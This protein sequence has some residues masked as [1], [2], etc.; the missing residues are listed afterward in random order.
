MALTPSSAAHQFCGACV[1]RE[2]HPHSAHPYVYVSPSLQDRKS[3]PL[4]FILAGLGLPSQM[5]GTN[6]QNTSST[7]EFLSLDI[8]KLRASTLGSRPPCQKPAPCWRDHVQREREAPLVGPWLSQPLWRRAAGTQVLGELQV[9]K[10]RG[11]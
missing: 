2:G 7:L 1:S 11:R 3:I 9:E 8:K 6:L 10:S 5:S 4:S